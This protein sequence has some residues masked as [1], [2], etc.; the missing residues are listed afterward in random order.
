MDDSSL[1]NVNCLKQHAA[2]L[3]AENEGPLQEI[4]AALRVV[5]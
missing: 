2:E 3:L 4:A 5:E 1:A